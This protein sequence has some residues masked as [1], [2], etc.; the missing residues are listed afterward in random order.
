MHI[1]GTILITAMAL[2]AT[3]AGAPEFSGGSGPYPALSEVDPFQPV[4]S[5]GGS[6]FVG[7]LGVE[8]ADDTGIRFGASYQT[9]RTSDRDRAGAKAY[10]SFEF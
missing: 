5:L 10:V 4:T 9:N 6:G 2:G 7:E 8:F 1:P 3:S